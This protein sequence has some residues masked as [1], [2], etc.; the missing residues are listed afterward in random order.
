SD[1]SSDRALS[2]QQM[3]PSAGV[4]SIGVA[5]TNTTGD[6]LTSFS[7]SYNGEQWRYIGGESATVM[8]FEYQIFSAGTSGLTAAS[9]WTSVSAL[10]FTSPETG[11]SSS[12]VDGYTDGSVFVS[13]SVSSFVWEDGE[14]LMLRWSVSGLSSRAIVGVDDVS[15]SAVPKTSSFAL[16]LGL[17]SLAVIPVIRRHISQ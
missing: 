7:L 14:E 3:S 2:Y 4:N 1:G 12:A 11:A 10:D 13:S 6:D 16:T 8:A 5:F 17:A 9:G 15:F